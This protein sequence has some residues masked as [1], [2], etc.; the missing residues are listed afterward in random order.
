VFLCVFLP[1][2][3]TSHSCFFGVESILNFENLMSDN[4]KSFS[5]KSA[6]L[7]SKYLMSDVSS[8]KS[9]NLMSVERANYEIILKPQ[10]GKD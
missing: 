6:S 2:W 1:L 3:F 5:L 10:G 7:M 4:L 8:L 9:K